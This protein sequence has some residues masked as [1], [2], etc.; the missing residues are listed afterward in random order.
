M[1]FRGSVVIV[2][3]SK[4]GD[5]RVEKE[6]VWLTQHQMPRVFQSTPQNIVMHLCNVFSSKELDAEATGKDFLVVRS[7]R[8]RPILPR[9]RHT[10]GRS[11]A[12]CAR[13]AHVEFD[14]A[15]ATT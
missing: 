11:R 14:S 2:C 12:T 9:I 7:Q 15:S 4:D 5:V 8:E 1:R 3:E 6:T 13:F 10:Y